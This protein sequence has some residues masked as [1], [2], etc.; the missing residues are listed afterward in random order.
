MFLY[1]DKLRTAVKFFGKRSVYFRHRRGHHLTDVYDHNKYESRL[2][3]SRTSLGSAIHVLHIMGCSKIGLI[4][5]D[6]CRLDGGVRYFWQYSRGQRADYERPF[7]IDYVPVD[8][9]RRCMYKNRSSDM[10]LTE[11]A[12]YW[13]EEGYHFND[14]CD[15]YNLS[16]ISVVEVFKKENLS[17]FIMSNSIMKHEQSEGG[18]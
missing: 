9:Y 1:E 13:E 5:F 4:G 11:I 17:S 14:K 16:P 8:H 18:S 6:C 3:E 12:Q 15:I 10:D 7:R 2:L